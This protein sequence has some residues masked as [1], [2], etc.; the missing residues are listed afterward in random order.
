MIKFRYK[1]KSATDVVEGTT[2]GAVDK[3]RSHVHK[4]STQLIG[5]VANE[6]EQSWD[7]CVRAVVVSI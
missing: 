5:A 6:Q 1:R 3:G 2:G 4:N 7:S